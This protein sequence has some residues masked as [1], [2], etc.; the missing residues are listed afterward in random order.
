VSFFCFQISSLNGK[1]LERS[2]P[3]RTVIHLAQVESNFNLFPLMCSNVGTPQIVRLQSW[4]SWLTSPTFWQRF[5][6]QMQCH[7]LHYFS[8]WALLVKNF[9]LRCLGAQLIILNCPLCQWYPLFSL[10]S[11]TCAALLL[12]WHSHSV[13]LWHSHVSLHMAQCH[14][15]LTDSNKVLLFCFLYSTLFGEIP[16]GDVLLLC[17]IIFPGWH[18]LLYP[19]N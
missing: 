13:L 12:E 18:E 5:D 8:I 10:E 4:H 19:A 14:W 11:S 6:P 2:F 17:S 15:G 7:C 3:V 9:T 1:Q 16:A